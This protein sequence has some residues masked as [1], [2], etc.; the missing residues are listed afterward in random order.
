MSWVEVGLDLVI[1][2]GDLRP[3]TEQLYAVCPE[4]TPSRWILGCLFILLNALTLEMILNIAHLVSQL[5][6]LVLEEESFILICCLFSVRT[7]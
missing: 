5:H 2:I 6:V 3:P 7:F 4:Q 1:H